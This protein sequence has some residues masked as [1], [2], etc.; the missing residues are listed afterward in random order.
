MTDARVLGAAYDALVVDFLVPLLEGREVK[1][2]QPIAPGCASFFAQTRS[3]S[4]DA[5]AR[6]FEALH[7]GAS[8]LTTIETLRWPSMGLLA[9]SAAMYDALY[10][11]DPS[12][13]RVFARSARATIRDWARGWISLVGVPQTRGEALARHVLVERF[14]H[15]RRKDV[16]VKNWAYTYRFFGRRPPANVVALPTIRFVRQEETTRPLENILQR[17]GDVGMLGLDLPGLLH[18]LKLRSPV[19]QLLR[20]PSNQGFRFSTSTLAA[21]SDRA[22]RG[23]VAGH[24]LRDEWQAAAVL[25]VAIVEPSLVEQPM[26][27]SIALQL[28]LEMHLVCALDGRAQTPTVRELVDP[29]AIRYA[30]LLVATFDDERAIR[31]LHAFDDDHRAI[32]QRRAEAFRPRVPRAALA[33]MQGLLAHALPHEPA[34]LP[35]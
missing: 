25:G 20:A 16:V 1:L 6:I 22:I 9:M 18:D 29:G 34:F 30:A 11:T 3:S 5:D 31:E 4:S 7:R 2:A 32:L 10:L 26:L 28:V 24:L 23:A 27:L 19:T 17:E 8:E 14:E 33:E 12:L 15:I 35:S 13:D 21:L